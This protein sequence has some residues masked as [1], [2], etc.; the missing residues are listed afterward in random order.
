GP[1]V[2]SDRIHRAIGGPD[3]CHREPEYTELFAR[4]RA[5]LLRVAG[6]ADDW[7][8]VLIG[9]SGQA[10][11]EAM[12]GAAG[13]PGHSLLACR[14]GIYGDRI[15]TIAERPGTR[16]VDVAAGH[17]DPI[18]VAGVEAALDADLDIDA[19]SVV[20]HETTT[21]LLN[22]VEAIARAAHRRGVL[23]LVDAISAFG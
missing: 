3:L 14:H 8:V 20:Y 9:G 18:D 12:A 17:T 7:A 5:K 6:V 11:L 16:V 13:P 21:G 2:V 10:A 19:V 15:A 22:P 23:T 1:T 4:V